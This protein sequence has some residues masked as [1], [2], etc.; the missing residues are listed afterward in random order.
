MTTG[1]ISELLSQMEQRKSNATRAQARVETSEE[2]LEA[3]K[4][5]LRD[6]YG[7]ADSEALLSILHA[8]EGELESKLADAQ[9]LLDQTPKA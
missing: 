4:E 5:L 2:A 3:Y 1:N 8:T 7:T 6:R 9:A